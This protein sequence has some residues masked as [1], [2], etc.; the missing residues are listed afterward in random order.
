[1]WTWL[2]RIFEKQFEKKNQ[3]PGTLWQP[4]DLTLDLYGDDGNFWCWGET[5]ELDMNGMEALE[6]VMKRRW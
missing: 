2:K 5:R 3:P 4:K 6:G 1:M